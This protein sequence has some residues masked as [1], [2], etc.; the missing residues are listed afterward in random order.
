MKVELWDMT[1]SINGMNAIDY[2]YHNRNIPV[3][4]DIFNNIHDV[5]IVTD[6]SGDIVL[7]IQVGAKIAEIY[8]ID[9]KLSTIEIAEEY[10]KI[11]EKERKEDIVNR[12]IEYA[13]EMFRNL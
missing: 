12:F 1:K 10:L 8:N 2:M 9:P 13:K 6:D 4:K 7:E 5:F 3:M 11:K